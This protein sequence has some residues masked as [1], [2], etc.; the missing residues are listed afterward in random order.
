MTLAQIPRYD[1]DNV[2]PVEGHAVVVGASMAGL[3]TGRVLADVFDTVTVI[4]QDPLPDQPTTR[5]GVPQGAHVH[6]LQEAGR[7]TLEDLFP[8]YGEELLSAGGLVIDAMSDFIHYEK[9]GFLADGEQRRPMY[10]ASRPLFEQIVRRRLADFDG[11]EIRPNCHQTDYLTNEDATAVEGIRAKAGG[12]RTELRADLVVDATGRTSQIG[13]WLE[14]N[15]YS[16]PPVD[17]VHIDIAYSSVLIE[18]PEADRRAFFVPPDA[19]RTRGAGV[20]PVENGRWLATIA[21]VHG[22]HPPTDVD[23]LRE[24]AETLPVPDVVRIFDEQPWQTDGVAH[25]PFP[26]NR[27]RRFEALDRFPDGLIVIGDA[28]SS[29]NPIYGQGM[30]VAALE[31]LVLHHTLAA[32]DGT[33]N[34][35]RFF[36][37]VEPIVDVPWAIA[38]GG[39]FEFAE[40]TGPKP[41]GT[42]LFNR[43]IARLLRKAHSDWRL[44]EAIVQVFMMTQPPRSLLRPGTAWRVLKPAQREL[45]MLSGAKTTVRGRVRDWGN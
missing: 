4:D 44:R 1:P 18:R 40:T 5:R 8:G 34:A 7:A 36:D 28:I 25:Y 30:S 11:V 13:T 9:G 10:C 22:D 27:R 16:A 19:P 42:D 26:S 15:G 14:E 35:L 41:R 24:F 20:F 43:Y 21:G 32:S 39:D 12:D 6:A 3:L 38:V 17:D 33:S 31:A 29:F 2:E 45:D 37:D 23:A